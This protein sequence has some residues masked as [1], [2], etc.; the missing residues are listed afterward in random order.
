MHRFNKSLQAVG[1]HENTPLPLPPPLHHPT[2]N[3]SVRSLPTFSTMN[4][5]T[6]HSAY[7]LNFSIVTD[8]SLPISYGTPDSCSQYRSHFFCRNVAF[9][10]ACVLDVCVCTCVIVC[11]CMCDRVCVCVCMH[12]L[13]CRHLLSESTNSSFLLQLSQHHDD[14]RFLIPYHLPKI[15]NCFW[16]GSLR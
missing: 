2:V 4:S 1:V 10:Y 14:R 11:I 9:E 15:C 5:R 12:V 13:M 6:S 8:S 3:P 16:S 7:S